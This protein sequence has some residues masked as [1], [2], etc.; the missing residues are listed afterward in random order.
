MADYSDNEYLEFAHRLLRR[1]GEKCTSNECRQK[2]KG[3]QISWQKQ[4]IIDLLNDR[5]NGV[6]RIDHILYTKITFRYDGNKKTKF[7][8]IKKSWL[9]TTL[10]L[11]I[12]RDCVTLL[13]RY[14]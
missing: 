12:E 1:V 10:S 8:S 2:K 5:P 14:R 4:D 11:K 7:V 6:R 3:Q 13:T 9:G